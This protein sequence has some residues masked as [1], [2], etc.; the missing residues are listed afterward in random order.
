MAAAAISALQRPG[1]TSLAEL[2]SCAEAF[3][4]SEQSELRATK[5]CPALQQLHAAGLA[6]AVHAFL[7]RL[8][9]AAEAQAQG[10]EL[11]QALVS[12]QRWEGLALAHALQGAR[13][14]R[15]CARAPS[16]PA[17]NAM[18]PHARG[19][20]SLLR[21]L[22]PPCALYDAEEI[23]GVQPTDAA[24]HAQRGAAHRHAAAAQD[25]AADLLVSGSVALLTRLT[26]CA[27]AAPV[28]TST[29]A[30]AVGLWCELC[31][32]VRR[33]HGGACVRV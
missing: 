11:Q 5:S 3:Q 24:T 29:G 25:V 28:A 1:A 20:R 30:E 23:Y 2:A 8:L 14:L 31:V 9:A 15:A 7:A 13:T 17:M 16:P 12:L 4:Q 26:F 33:A 27:P 22:Q 32:Q 21:L 6:P 19:R 10:Q 18:A